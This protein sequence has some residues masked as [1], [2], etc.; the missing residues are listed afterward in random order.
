MD[1]LHHKRKE[2]LHLEMMIK[3][4]FLEKLKVVEHNVQKLKNK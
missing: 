1:G 2:V 3:I 4:A